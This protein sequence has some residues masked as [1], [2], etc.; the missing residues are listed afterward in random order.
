MRFFLFL[1]ILFVFKIDLSAQHKKIT[2]LNIRIGVMQQGKLNAITDVSGV[3]VGHTTLLKGEA[4][5]TGV[6]AILPHGGN[7]FQQKVPA[8]VYLGNAFGK[9]AGYTQVKEL[10]NIESPIVLTNTLNIATGINAIIKYTL[11]QKGNESVQSVNA[12]VGETND[13]FLNDIRG[14]HVS[15]ADVLNAI[16]TAKSGPVT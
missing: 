15:E 14:G 9:L 11:A 5:R 10:G 12:I 13:G 7:L 1:F 8:A 6:T 4:V 16:N 3:K 2:E